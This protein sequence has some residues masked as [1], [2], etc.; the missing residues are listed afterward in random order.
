MAWVAGL[1]ATVVRACAG[2]LP[3]PL[4]P[5]WAEAGVATQLRHEG[6]VPAGARRIVPACETEE[7]EAEHPAWE[8]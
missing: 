8:P 6:V 4:Q 2:L 7:K 1:G 5:A 3:T